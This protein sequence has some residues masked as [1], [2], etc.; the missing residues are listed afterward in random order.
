MRGRLFRRDKCDPETVD[1]FQ[2]EIYRILEEE[3]RE[4]F[5]ILDDFSYI[6]RLLIVISTEFVNRRMR[7]KS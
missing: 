5:Y 4:V 3:G 2:S 7:E 1:Y 6:F